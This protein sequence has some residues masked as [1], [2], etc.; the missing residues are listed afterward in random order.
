MAI[1][2]VKKSNKKTRREQIID[3]GIR[4]F[5]RV[6]FTDITIAAVAREAKCGHSLVYHY[7]SNINALYDAA[8]DYVAASFTTCMERLKTVDTTPELIFVGVISRFI[9]SLQTD[10]MYAYYLNLFSYEDKLTPMNPKVIKL[11][12]MWTGLFLEIIQNAQDAGRLITILTSEEILQAVLTIFQGLISSQIVNRTVS[13]SKL[14][15]SYIYLP[16][17]KGVN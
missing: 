16:L 6:P 3:A 14:K 5:A 9:E 13:S 17:L 2:K 15:A 12:K 4:L 10:Q 8:V 11:Q 1:I 7:F